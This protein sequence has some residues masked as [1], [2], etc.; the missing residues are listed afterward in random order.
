MGKMIIACLFFFH[1]N[2]TDAPILFFSLPPPPQLDEN[3]CKY[4]PCD[5][6]AQCTNTLGSFTCT[7][8]PG[9]EGDGF[10]CTGKFFFTKNFHWKI[11]KNV[12]VLIVFC[13]FFRLND[14]KKPKSQFFDTKRCVIG[15]ARVF[16]VGHISALLRP[17]SVL[18]FPP[19]SI[20]SPFGGYHSAG[21][22]AAAQQLSLD[23]LAW[24]TFTTF[25]TL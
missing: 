13:F 4:R 20:L 9:Y 19:L 16:L 10:T 18:G 23:S 15:L 12:P 25:I 3:E 11:A 14:K 17:G 8:Y 6:F 24:L 5:V 22:Y 2:Q 21:V 1:W 7:C